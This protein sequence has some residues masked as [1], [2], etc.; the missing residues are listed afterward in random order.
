MRRESGSRA[1]FNHSCGK[2]V[3]LKTKASAPFFVAPLRKNQVVPI[4]A[5][6]SLLSREAVALPA[7]GAGKDERETGT[8]K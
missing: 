5:S 8:K 7:G 3:P 2:Q 4:Y 6:I 1:P